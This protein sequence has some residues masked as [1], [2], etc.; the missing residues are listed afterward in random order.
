MCG[1]KGSKITD[2][3]RSTAMA[4][5]RKSAGVGRFRG[6]LTPATLSSPALSSAMAAAIVGSSDVCQAGGERTVF[7][8]RRPLTFDFAVIRSEL[9]AIPMGVAMAKGE[10]MLR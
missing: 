3:R 6:G 4:A 7:L 1:L 9:G 8:D 5:A 10:D 2:C